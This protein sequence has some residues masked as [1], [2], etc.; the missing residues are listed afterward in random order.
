VAD[1]VFLDSLAI[2]GR[3]LVPLCF[4]GY[5]GTVP[6][7]AAAGTNTELAQ[8]VMTRALVAIVDGETGRP[9]TAPADAPGPWWQVRYTDNAVRRAGC[10]CVFSSREL[11]EW[12]FVEAYTVTRLPSAFLGGAFFTAPGDAADCTCCNA[13]V[14]DTSVCGQEHFCSSLKCYSRYLLCSERPAWPFT[15]NGQPP[16]AAD[17][18]PPVTVLHALHMWKTLMSGRLQARMAEQKTT[19]SNVAFSVSVECLDPWWFF[20]IFPA[21]EKTR[22]GC[23]RGVVTL[24]DRDAKE[25]IFGPGYFERYT[26]DLPPGR[27]TLDFEQPPRVFLRQTVEV[28]SDPHMVRARM[29]QLGSSVV[30]PAIVSSADLLVQ[31]S[32]LVEV[33]GSFS[34]LN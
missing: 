33:R 34:R 7:S 11:E 32:W 27:V 4:R 19:A 15:Q 13:R 8:T 21:S 28:R 12:S 23:W 16:N 17:A 18:I 3:L 29:L 14:G 6:V 2:P 31:T 9:S 20:L 24:D 5:M 25:A 10:V 22:D 30:T 1:H 26:G